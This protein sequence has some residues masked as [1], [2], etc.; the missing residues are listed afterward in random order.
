M[1]EG[2]PKPDQAEAQQNQ[3]A[4]KNLSLAIAEV[5][6][7]YLH[8]KNILQPGPKKRKKLHDDWTKT[9]KITYEDQNT[10]E[11]THLYV[12]DP[13]KEKT[14]KLYDEH[15]TDTAEELY[16]KHWTDT[17]EKHPEFKEKIIELGEAM[18][19]ANHIKKE[20][21][22]PTKPNFNRTL[23]DPPYFSHVENQGAKDFLTDIL[24]SRMTRAKGNYLEED[25][26]I[27]NQVESMGTEMELIGESWWIFNDSQET[28]KVTLKQTMTKVLKGK[29]R[30]TYQEPQPTQ[31]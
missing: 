17:A 12:Y 4:E 5:I 24:F 11:V 29:L 31:K 18:K 27:Q 2:E 6:P 28:K 25:S 23:C 1:K 14:E 8:T 30:V 16:N 26:E 21:L 3:E 22:N 7:L 10:G 15:W 13:Y 9:K 19:I 20:N